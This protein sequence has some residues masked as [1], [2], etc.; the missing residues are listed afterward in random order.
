MIFDEYHPAV[1]EQRTQGTRRPAWPAC[2]LGCS[3]HSGADKTLRAA[4]GGQ[5]LQAL[6]LAAKPRLEFPNGKNVLS[7]SQV[8]R[9][10]VPG[11]H[12]ISYYL[13]L[14]NIDIH[15]IFFGSEA[16]MYKKTSNISI[17]SCITKPK[18][19]YVI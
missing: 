14:T 19:Q 6:L 17:F 12:L 11:G 2:S 13:R 15:K 8:L 1:T 3:L 4:L 7:S 10:Y 16:I 5:I 18:S 9:R